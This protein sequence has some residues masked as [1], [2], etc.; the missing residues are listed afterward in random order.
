MDLS[1]V[2][3]RMINDFVPEGSYNRIEKGFFA[4]KDAFDSD[5]KIIDTF[6][7]LKNAIKGPHFDIIIILSLSEPRK[8]NVLTTLIGQG[9]EKLFEKIIY[10]IDAKMKV[11]YTLFI[12]EILK[13]NKIDLCIRLVQRLNFMPPG[14]FIFLLNMAIRTRR[15]DLV[16][17]FVEK[18]TDKIIEPSLEYATPEI[19][20]YLELNYRYV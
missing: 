7:G 5:G 9:Y 14:Q 8:I 11:D 1:T 2:L 16:R 10:H 15:L 3:T 13:A 18:D 4:L 6:I 19:R 17:A 20:K 12:L